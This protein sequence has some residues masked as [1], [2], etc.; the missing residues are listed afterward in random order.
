M[1]DMIG[2]INTSANINPLIKEV[3]NEKKF[4]KC[5]SKILNKAFVSQKERHRR[6]GCIY[7]SQ[8]GTL[9]SNLESGQVGVTL[10]GMGTL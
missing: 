2:Q 5:T 7:R 6:C 1:A 4:E 9:R 8:Y 3:E 10:V